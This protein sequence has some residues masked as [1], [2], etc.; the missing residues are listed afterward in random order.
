MF[1]S[2]ISVTLAEIREHWTIVD[3]FRAGQI[4]DAQDELEYR[5]EL[6]RGPS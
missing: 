2:R 3:V 4:L 6:K 5:E 1:D